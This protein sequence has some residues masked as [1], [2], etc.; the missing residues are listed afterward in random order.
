MIEANVMS[1]V[2][3]SVVDVAVNLPLVINLRPGLSHFRY[4]SHFIP[5]SHCLT[6]VY[7]FALWK[8]TVLAAL[9]R[10]S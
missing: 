1:V 7:V 4:I 2:L 6:A 5:L 10:R 3:S 8:Y 9:W